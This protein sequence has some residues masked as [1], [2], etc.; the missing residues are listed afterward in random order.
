VADDAIHGFVGKWWQREPEMRVAAVFCPPVQR[1]VFE[2]WGALL[3]E[4][5]EAAFELS[6]ARVTEG[7][8]GWWA[9]ELAGWAQARSRHPL[10]RVLAPLPAPWVGLANAW[11]GITDLEPA[12]ADTRAAIAALTPAARAVAA[13]EQALLATAAMP[14]AGDA[15][16]A[17]ATHWLAMR[18]PEG[19]VAAD[20]ARVPMHL[21]ARHG[22]PAFA[23]P[24]PA[25]A[26]LLRDWSRELLAAPTP[27]ATVGT[28][29][30]RCRTAFDRARLAR[31]AG[32]GQGGEP[33]ALGTLWR[34][35]RAARAG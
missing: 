21:L 17:I 7:K 16:D 14:D 3:H 20:R 15:S 34:A 23:D 9:E 22:G 6:D 29:F 24:G 12:Q 25:R 2:A 30:R 31:L 1:P 19:L 33:A 11:A 18:L 4:L 35:W 28:V 26:S 13:V 27:T 8:C 32:D 5:R 10:G